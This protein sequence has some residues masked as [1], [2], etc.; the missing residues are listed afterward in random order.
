M[1]IGVS[2]PHNVQTE[3]DANCTNRSK[4]IKDDVS[5]SSEYWEVAYQIW[6]LETLSQIECI[7]FEIPQEQ[8]LD[9]NIQ[10]KNGDSHK[11]N[12]D[13]LV[14]FRFPVAFS[15]SLSLIVVHGIL[16]K[17]DPNPLS[18]TKDDRGYFRILPPPGCEHTLDIDALAL[19]RPMHTGRKR[20]SFQR[21]FKI[22]PAD[23]KCHSWAQY[24]LSPNEKYLIQ[25][26]GSGPPSEASN[27]RWIASAYKDS[28]IDNWM[29]SF[30]LVASVGI[31]FR[32][33]TTKNTV[34]RFLSF[35]PFLPIV[36][37]CRLATL[38][39][40]FFMEKGKVISISMMRSLSWLNFN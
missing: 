25:I 19:S 14:R 7:R 4:D 22:I 23:H 15:S 37:I 31:Q 30:Y 34:D 33:S 39:L 2:F 24:L 29:P 35:H 8:L 11:D 17:L 12:N 13:E 40:W 10:S 38:S 28:S 27:R 9:L 21:G 3:H 6:S 36:A 18:L 32:V 20:F 5:I 26:N 16:L 1:D